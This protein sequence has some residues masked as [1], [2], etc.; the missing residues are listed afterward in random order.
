MGRAAFGLR[1]RWRLAGRPDPASLTVAVDG[2]ALPATAADGTLRWSF[3]PS[4]TTLTFGAGAVPAPGAELTV[5]Y[6]AACR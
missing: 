5:T 4:R 6:R 1:S 3:D 2:A